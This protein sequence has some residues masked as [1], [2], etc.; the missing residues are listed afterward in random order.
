MI[1]VMRFTYDFI[2]S[3]DEI[4]LEYGCSI[5]EIA[6]KVLLELGKEN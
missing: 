4:K 3:M 5:G 2:D 1:G 6:E